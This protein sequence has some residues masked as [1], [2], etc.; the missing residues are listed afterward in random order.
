MKTTGAADSVRCGNRI[1]RRQRALRLPD[2]PQIAVHRGKPK[3]PRIALGARRDEDPCA[4]SGRHLRSREL[5][6]GRVRGI[7]IG[8]RVLAA[9]LGLGLLVA[10]MVLVVGVIAGEAT[11]GHYD[12]WAERT[13][14]PWSEIFSAGVWTFTLALGMTAA[15][16]IG[17]VILGVVHVL[18]QVWRFAAQS[19]IR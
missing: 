2:L 1:C 18:V 6:S 9:M 11:H 12:Q 7:I 8:W 5:P 13:M 4:R 16:I 10:A 19:L 17:A 3:M 14:P 15:S